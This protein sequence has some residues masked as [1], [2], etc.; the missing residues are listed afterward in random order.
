M[1]PEE[2]A[3]STTPNETPPHVAIAPQPT[4]TDTGTGTGTGN[5]E[6]PGDP[7]GRARRQTLSA[8]LT[9]I[10]GDET[11]DSIMID[12]LITILG[13]RGRAGLILIFAFP[14]VL[15]ALPGLS[16]V[17]GVPLLYL[18]LQMMLGRDPW[19][20]RVIGRR[21]IPRSRF[22]GLV[23]NLAPWLAR[24]E[25]LLRPR[26]SWLVGHRAERALGAV[27]LVLA[28]VLALPIPFGNMLPAFAI[29]LIALGVL[30]RDGVWVVIGMVTGLIS[31]VIVSGVV[32]ALA[33]SAIFLLVNAFG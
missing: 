18:S 33:R 4:G 28:T 32:Y 19:L 29:C 11:R 7:P 31:L 23:D 15:P 30:E 3:H 10:A 22:A 27:F 12:D 17:L 2:S 26:W 14:N 21:S 9:N 6:A 20:P 25:R 8:I 5:D 24:A 16:G 13:G 1:S